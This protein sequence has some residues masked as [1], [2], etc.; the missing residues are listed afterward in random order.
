[1]QKIKRYQQKYNLLLNFKNEMI[2]YLGKS[3]CQYCSL[4]RKMEKMKM[5][6]AGNL[7]EIP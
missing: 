6:I 2:H 3:L 4:D 5:E 1:M 7:L